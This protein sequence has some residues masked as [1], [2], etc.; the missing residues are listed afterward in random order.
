MPP[1]IA[2]LFLNRVART[3]DKSWV[4]S[5]NSAIATVKYGIISNTSHNNFLQ[6]VKLDHIVWKNEVY[7]YLNGTSEKSI[8]SFTSH[9]EC[10][11]GN[12]YYQGEGKEKYENDSSFRKLEDP[13]AKVHSSGVKALQAHDNNRQEETI[14]FLEKMEQASSE[15]I[16]LLTEL[17]GAQLNLNSNEIVDKTELDLF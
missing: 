11:L 17:E 9:Q 16:G 10:R 15:V 4:L 12:W 3:S 13:H 8:N 2:H 5:P 6:T 14:L 1:I 7:A